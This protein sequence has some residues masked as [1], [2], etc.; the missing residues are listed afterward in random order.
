MAFNC[1]VF[2][3]VEIGSYCQ[4]GSRISIISNNHPLN[5][6]TIYVNRQLL[7]GIAAKDVESSPVKIGNDVWVGDNAVILK[8][9]TIGNGAV[10][11]AGAVVTHNVPD[12]AI[13]VGNPARVIRKRFDDHIIK[14]L[15]ELKWWDLNFRQLEDYA[16]LFTIDLN[17]DVTES[18][19]VIQKCIKKKKAYSTRSAKP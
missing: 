14:L 7:N 18:T 6:A 4:L 3:Y 11:G 1:S 8:G 19:E 2:G 10:I 12:Y 9:I 5:K 16:D 13:A 15:L 17:R